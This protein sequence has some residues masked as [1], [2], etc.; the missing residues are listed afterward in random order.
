[1]KMAGRFALTITAAVLALSP[2]WFSA[3]AGSAAFDFTADGCIP[4]CG[5]GPYGTVIVTQDGKVLDF[6]VTL[7][8]GLYFAPYSGGLDTLAFN[9]V[10]VNSVTLTASSDPRLALVAGSFSDA[11]FTGTHKGASD[12]FDHAIELSPY[13]PRSFKLGPPVSSFSFQLAAGDRFH[14][15]ELILANLGFVK[16][17]QGDRVY[18]CRRTVDV[19]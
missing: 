6:S 7:K 9:L 15:G 17:D 10:G 1:M 2:C 11:P 19:S 8:D 5:S 3:S 12:F 16:D 13:E 14:L 18:A 4:T